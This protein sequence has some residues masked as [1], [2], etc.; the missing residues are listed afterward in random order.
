MKKKIV[1]FCSTIILTIVCIISLSEAHENQKS[2]PIDLQSIIKIALA[3]GE[4]G[5]SFCT[6]ECPDGTTISVPCECD[7]IILPGSVRCIA[8]M[9]CGYMARFTLAEAQCN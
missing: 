2:N 9:E 4:A 6:N 5:G 8:S 3:D 1:L 7:C